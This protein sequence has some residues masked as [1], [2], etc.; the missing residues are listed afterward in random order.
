MDTASH[1]FIKAQEG[2]CNVYSY[3]LTLRCYYNITNNFP[4]G[5]FKC[6]REVELYDEYSFEHEFF[7][8][9][10]KSFSLM[11]KL[12]LKNKKPQNNKQ[13]NKSKEDIGHLSVVEYPHLTDLILYEVHYDYIEEF[14]IDTKMCLTNGVVLCMKYKSLKEVIRNFTRNE[15]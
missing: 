14:L 15:T 11:E 10:E 12:T 8:R 5:L 7:L 3:P 2:Q 1:L 6:V 13:Y 9:I 4:G